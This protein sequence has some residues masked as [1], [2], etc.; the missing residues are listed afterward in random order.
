LAVA[1]REPFPS[2][3][4]FRIGSSPTEGLRPSAVLSI[5]FREIKPSLCSSSQ[6]CASIAMP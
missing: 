2:S 1:W 3:N 6:E 5:L 4:G